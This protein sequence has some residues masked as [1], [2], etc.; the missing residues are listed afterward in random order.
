MKASGWARVVVADEC[1]AIRQRFR[2]SRKVVPDTLDL[3]AA[4]RR[5]VK[6]ADHL[7]TLAST[8]LAGGYT[9]Q[10]A[11]TALAQLTGRIV[12]GVQDRAG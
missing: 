12:A 10:E 11:Q 7:E 6:L 9:A 4:R 8:M 1:R 5:G 3:M 2:A